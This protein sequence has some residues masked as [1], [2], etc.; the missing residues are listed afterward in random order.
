MNSRTLT[1]TRKII[2][3]PKNSFTKERRVPVITLSGDWLTE[4]IG[5]NAGDKVVVKSMPDNP[6]ALIIERILAGA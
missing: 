4:A 1:I 6:N 3:R 5:V 2:P